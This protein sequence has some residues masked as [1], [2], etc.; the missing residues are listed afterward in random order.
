M[1]VLA[2]SVF[3]NDSAAVQEERFSRQKHCADFPHQAIEYCL[4]EA[5]I[6]LEPL[7]NIAFYDKP[8]LKFERRLELCH[9][10][11]PSGFRSFVRVVERC[12]GLGGSSSA[13]NRLESGAGSGSRT[14]L[15][16]LGS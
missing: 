8:C 15:T 1:W 11:A 7:D 16:S 9:T 6:G 5:G 13:K 3:Y 14:R 12:G 10:F 4:S 2:I